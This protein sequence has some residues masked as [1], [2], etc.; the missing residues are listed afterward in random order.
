MIWLGLCAFC[1]LLEPFNMSE[2]ENGKRTE[3]N[4]NWKGSQEKISI[5]LREREKENVEKM[6]HESDKMTMANGDG[7]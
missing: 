4:L 6:T 7:E 5:F 1:K 3:P 2:L